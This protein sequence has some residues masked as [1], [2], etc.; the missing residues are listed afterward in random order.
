MA[1]KLFGFWRSLAA[2][3]VRIALNLKGVAFEEV[4][5]DL[6]K[7]EQFADGYR[8]V[9]PQ[10]VVPALIDG[11]VGNDYG[12]AILRLS[13]TL[14]LVEGTLGAWRSDAVP[15]IVPSA[16]AARRLT[17]EAVAFIRANRN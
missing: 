7:G 8:A 10:M 6:L 12:R 4:A 1:V 14:A 17:D 9:N 5:V 15:V 16:V 3:R 11:D 13:E 2:F